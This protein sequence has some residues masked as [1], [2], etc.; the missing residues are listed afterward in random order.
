MRPARRDHPPPGSGR[1]DQ[2]ILDV[3]NET[4]SPV[5]TKV[6]QLLAK[7][8]ST[9][10]DAFTAK[11]STRR[12]ASAY[13][14]TAAT[15]FD[16]V[17]LVLSQP[18]RHSGRPVSVTAAAAYYS[19]LG[20]RHRSGG[21]NDHCPRLPLM[22]EVPMADCFVGRQ[23]ILDRDGRVYAYDLLY[24]SSLSNEV[25]DVAPALHSEQRSYRF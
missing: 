19:P 10:F 11:A 15:G 23:S 14:A 16:S 4:A 18:S 8:E 1:T 9:E 12:L 7:A 13:R 2:S 17:K 24:R 25:G 20:S 3:S 5:L 21:R 6:R 22:K